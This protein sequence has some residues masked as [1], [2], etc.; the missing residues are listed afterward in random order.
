MREI[1]RQKIVDSLA[2]A[3][4]AS[5][6]RDVRVPG[7]PGK[8]KA[9]VGPRRAGR[10]R[11]ATARYL[12]MA[13]EISGIVTSRRYEGELP[14][15]HLVDD[16]SFIP[17]NSSTD[18]FE[19]HAVSPFVELTEAIEQ[20]AKELSADGACA[21][22]ETHYH[23][24]MGGQ[25]AVVWQDGQ[26]VLGPLISAALQYAP[27][28]PWWRPLFARAAA[29]DEA[30]AEENDSKVQESDGPINE[31]LR[32]IGVHRRGEEDEFDTAGLGR[33]RSNDGFLSK[34]CVGKGGA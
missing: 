2:S 7:V 20:S 26:T 34:W 4:P 24:G 13:H 8:A 9:V 22:V 1:I 19:G 11:S 18:G 32:S 5:T 10:C 14:S 27:R 6:R 25:M 16:F 3:P 28:L 17:L 23:G 12:K 30:S 29:V 31:A 15:C 33:S 21:Y